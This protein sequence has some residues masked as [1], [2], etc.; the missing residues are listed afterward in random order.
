MS[1][2]F[3][4]GAG[5]EVIQDTHGSGAGRARQSRKARVGFRGQMGPE[6]CLDFVQS[7]Y[8]H[9]PETV[10][11]ARD[12]IPGEGWSQTRTPH[13]SAKRI[14]VALTRPATRRRVRCRTSI[15]KS[16]SVRSEER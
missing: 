12:G 7:R 11:R 8:G 13:I 1:V 16:G 14:S 3:E 10:Y 6:E 4:R 9:G 5:F 15:T 2:E